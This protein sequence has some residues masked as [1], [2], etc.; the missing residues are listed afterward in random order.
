MVNMTSETRP[1]RDRL[2]LLP[3]WWNP[4]GWLQ[5]LEIDKR[6]FFEGATDFNR[7]CGKVDVCDTRFLLALSCH[8]AEQPKAARVRGQQFI[9]E[10]VE[11]SSA[12]GARRMWLPPARS[13]PSGG[14]SNWNG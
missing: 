12:T 4:Q 10:S 9:S 7:A 13:I 2:G 3:D 8:F 6:P 1:L 5:S 11:F 14:R